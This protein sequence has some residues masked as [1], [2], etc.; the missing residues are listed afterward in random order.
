MADVGRVFPKSYKQKRPNSV[1][2]V[3]DKTN[4]TEEG[5]D[6]LYHT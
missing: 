3:S 1:N 2:V 5:L 6:E 4:Q